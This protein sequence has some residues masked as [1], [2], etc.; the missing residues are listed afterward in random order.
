[1]TDF[2]AD[3]GFDQT[4]A[5]LCAPA[6]AVCSRAKTVLHDKFYTPH[7]VA[8]RCVARV[9]EVV[10]LRPDDLYIEPSAG[11][12]AFCAHL[13]G[14]RLMALD[15]APEA[16]DIETQ[17]FLTFQFPDHAGRLIVIGNPPFGHNGTLARAFL[18]KAMEHADTVAYILPAS[19]AKPSMQRG[20]DRF[21]HLVHEES[22]P[23]QHFET[24]L[25]D[26]IVNT[27]FQIWRRQAV[28]RDIA[29]ETI[30]ETDLAF[31]K[32]LNQADLVIRRVG[33]R[34]G[35]ILPV[36]DLDADGAPPKG[37]ANS[38][39]HY[40]RSIGCDPA[41]LATRLETLGL[42][43]LAAENG[44]MPSLPKPALIAA[45]DKVWRA[46][47]LP[48]PVSEAFADEAGMHASERLG[49]R[50]GIGLKD[51]GAP[52]R[53]DRLPGAARM[54]VVGDDTANAISHSGRSSNWS[55][56]GRLLGEFTDGREADGSSGEVDCAREASVPLRSPGIASQPQQPETSTPPQSRCPWPALRDLVPQSR[57]T[58]RIWSRS[59]GGRR[60]DPQ[61]A[62]GHTP[63]QHLQAE[64]WACAGGSARGPPAPGCRTGGWGV[65]PARA[66][67]PVKSGKL[68][69]GSTA[70]C[71]P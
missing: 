3:A 13:P 63:L 64:D 24:H 5:L 51:F 43:A 71:K 34:A 28:P 62:N 70:Q 52:D 18:R 69:Q 48:C 22:L 50:C 32:D 65:I 47:E 40:I 33:A 16:P 29:P 38:S 19:Y 25:G 11:A 2:L 21:F 12:G 10:G 61:T 42:R 37:Y 15:I 4:T 31:T 54:D 58:G 6:S 41:T 46:K 14:D 53:L 39:N 57:A 9:M 17:D 67:S 55:D 56:Q 60:S 27:V 68:L 23:G 26:R 20:I 49:A 44:I 30:G 7:D 45:Y 59:L 66:F 36:P 1:M 35:V 8:S